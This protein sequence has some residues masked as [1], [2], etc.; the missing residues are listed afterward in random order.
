M[1]FACPPLDD[2]ECRVIERIDELRHNLR[3]QVH[4]PRRWTGLLARMTR[5]RDLR[6]SNSIEG[7]NVSDEDAIA[8][9]DGEEPE[10]ADRPTWRAIVGYRSAMDYILQRCR[11]DTFRFTDDLILAIHFMITQDDLEANPGNWRPGWVCVRNTATRE[12]VHE[13]VDRDLLVPLIHELTQYMNDS[14][15]NP[16]IIKA[17]MTHLNLAMLHP[18]SDGN[19]RVA[20]CLHTAVLANEG[21]A[22]PIFSSIEEY[23]G[24]NQQTYYDVLA[25]VGGGGWNPN[26][27]CRPWIRFCLT[28]HYRQA[29]TLLR[30]T[31]EVERIY[32]DL[33]DLVEQHGLQERTALAL[34]QA[35]LRHTVRNASYRVSAGISVSLASRDLKALA[36]VG[37][38]DAK[39]QRRGRRYAAGSELIAI[40]DRHRLPRDS[41]DPFSD[42][43]IV[44]RQAPLFGD[45]AP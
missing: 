2:A 28:G 24:R 38:L 18:F 14:D 39:G 40:R 17:S 29:Q 1:L 6:A 13:G 10:D 41:T 12:I 43:E 32:G 4:A 19:G 9:I 11:D 44:S 27:D 8:A 21:I 36:D 35:A 20:R 30:R 33:I 7:I 45:R 42:P 5:A 15:D 3:Y 25:E 31:R 26:R 22:S 34:L 23:I 16:S 37:L